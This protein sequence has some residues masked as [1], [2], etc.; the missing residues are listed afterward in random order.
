MNFLIDIAGSK[1][2]CERHQILKI[3]RNVGKES[4]WVRVGSYGECRFISERFN[5]LN[6]SW[7]HLTATNAEESIMNSDIAINSELLYLNSA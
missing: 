3:R 7:S 2:R 6:V 5:G 4:I 1:S